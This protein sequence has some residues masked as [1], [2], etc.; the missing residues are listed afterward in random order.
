M[1]G[2][3]D[4]VIRRIERRNARR[5]ED[6]P[7]I[8]YQDVGAMNDFNLAP[9]EWRRMSALDRRILHYYR[10]MRNHYIDSARE[11]AE[12]EAERERKARDVMDKMPKT[13][14]RKRNRRKP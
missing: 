10:V 7:T 3:T 11:A 12:Q 6:P 5:D 1:I 13:I 9:A 8:L 4:P 2:L 14:P